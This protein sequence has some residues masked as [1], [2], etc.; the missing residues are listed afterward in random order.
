MMHHRIGN[1]EINNEGIFWKG[2]GYEYTIIKNTLLD[3]RPSS[4]RLFD[5]HLHLA[6]KTW[7]TANDMH[8]FNQAFLYAIN[9][10]RMTLPESMSLEETLEEQAVILNISDDEDDE[11]TI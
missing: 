6:E 3:A 9:A 10:Y 5:W 8:D 2:E 1:W 7:V 11:L 4:P